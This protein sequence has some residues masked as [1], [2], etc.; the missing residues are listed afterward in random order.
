MRSPM[1][2][3]IVASY[4][5]VTTLHGASA[6]YAGVIRHDV[7]DSQYTSLAQ[8]PQF[9]PVG[10]LNF[11]PGASFPLCTGTLVAPRWVLT[12]GHCVTNFSGPGDTTFEVGGQTYQT[13]EYMPN[14]FYDNQTIGE[15]DL[16]LMRLDRPVTN[17]TPA[18]RYR[19]TGE[20]GRDFVTVGFGEFGD[21][22]SGNAPGTH[23]T[24]RAGTNTWDH[25]GAF[26]FDFADHT[27]LFDF[28][29]PTDPSLS[30]WGADAP[31]PTEYLT[32]Q[33]DS[34]SGV[35]IED[36]G[37]WLLAGVQS[38]GIRL[39]GSGPPIMHYG[40][41]GGSMAVSPFNDWI[42]TVIPEPATGGLLLLVA[43]ACLTRRFG[44]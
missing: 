14:P 25:R 7:P 2:R 43:G 34:G 44:S 37:E 23:G 8:Q 13:T 31:L 29:H 5:A 21:G 18:A 20:L 16:G 36:G 41:V 1:H 32:T 30:T 38:F 39:T 11:A 33:G 10:T 22:I 4:V 42:D 15:N 3:I 40:D 24:K 6:A 27:L 12:A 26:I 35:F 17:V 28:D 9:D 19:G